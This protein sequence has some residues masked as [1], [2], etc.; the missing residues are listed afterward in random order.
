MSIQYSLSNAE[1]EATIQNKVGQRYQVRR[2]N[3]LSD[4]KNTVGNILT[5]MKSQRDLG[6]AFME[7]TRDEHQRY[8]QKLVG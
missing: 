5:W 2:S 7:Y 8:C 4:W 3:Q 6:I 1:S